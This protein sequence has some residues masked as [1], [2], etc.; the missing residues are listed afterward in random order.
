[1][2]Q[3][4]AVITFEADAEIPEETIIELKRSIKGVV[5]NEVICGN[6]EDYKEYQRILRKH[7]LQNL[8]L[9]DLNKML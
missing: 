7:H 5:I 1:M 3:F 2:E 9:D 6:Y 8:N 4:T